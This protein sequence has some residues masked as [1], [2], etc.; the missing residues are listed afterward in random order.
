MCYKQGETFKQWR[1]RFIRLIPTDE[2]GA[3]GIFKN[4][5]PCSSSI[6]DLRGCAVFKSSKKFLLSEYPS[7]VIHGEH[8]TPNQKSFCFREES[9]RDRFFDALTNVIEGRSWDKSANDL[10]QEAAEAAAA[11]E[12]SAVS[13]DD[14]RS[15]QMNYEAVQPAFATVSE[16]DRVRM[17][18]A[19]W[20]LLHSN[21]SPEFRK[22]YEELK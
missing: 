15:S 8:L 1:P 5:Q 7:F 22:F 14:A 12:A 11:Q 16:Q 19:D 6:E 18:R 20:Y 10:A 2:S 13:G 4:G 21:G 9:E 3:L 17:G